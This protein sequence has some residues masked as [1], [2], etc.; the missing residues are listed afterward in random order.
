MRSLPRILLSAAPDKSNVRGMNL[1]NTPFALPSNTAFW[2]CP[3]D[4]L[5]QLWEFWWLSH[6]GCAQRFKR[7]FSSSRPKSGYGPPE[8]RGMAKTSSFYS[9]FAI[10]RLLGIW[11]EDSP[12]KSGYGKKCLFLQQLC[13]TPTFWGTVPRL[14]TN[15]QSRHELVVLSP[16]KPTLSHLSGV[17]RGCASEDIPSFL[18]EV[19]LATLEGDKIAALA[20]QR[21]RQ[22][23]W[24]K[25]KHDDTLESLETHRHNPVPTSL[26]CAQQK[27]ARRSQSRIALAELKAKQSSTSQFWLSRF[28]SKSGSGYKVTSSLN[29]RVNSRIKAFV[30]VSGRK[31]GN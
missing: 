24:A 19:T 27:V 6:G 10:P 7:R 14:W 5:T 9:I 21:A 1:C 31:M 13:H 29:I 11:D 30:V 23:A 15:R 18:G 12:R 28:R 16:C 8:S 2:A 25:R 22:R 4:S 3:Q 26:A 20:A 17:A